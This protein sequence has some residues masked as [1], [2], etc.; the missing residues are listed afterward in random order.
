MD[1]LSKTW[2][3]HDLPAVPHLVYPAAEA[4][5]SAL[6]KIAGYAYETI[7]IFIKDRV[8][9]WGWA[10]DD[11][12]RLGKFLVENPSEIFRLAKLWE[13]YIKKFKEI[14]EKIRD[15]EK[16]SDEEL[17]SLYKKFYAVYLN[18]YSIPLLANAFDTYFQNWLQNKVKN[19]TDFLLLT[20]PVKESFTQKEVKELLSIKKG[21]DFLKNIEKHAQKYFWL[22]N[23][24]AQAKILDKDYFIK[25]H[26]SEEIIEIDKVDKKPVI[27]KYSLF[28]DLI[29]AAEEC[30]YW[31][32]ER[33]K[34]NMIA[35]HF[36][37][38]FLREF[39]KRNNMSLED[40]KNVLPYE[41]ENVDKKQIDA[42][43]Q[44]ILIVVSQDSHQIHTGKEAMDLYNKMYPSEG[45]DKTE[46]RGTPACLGKAK[47]YA[48]IIFGEKEFNKLEENDIL[49]T[50]MTRPEFVPIMSKS[51]AI[52]TDEGGITCHAAIV[53]REMDKPCIIGTNMATKILKDGDLV[54]VDA[55]NGIVKILKRK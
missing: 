17:F 42:R 15:L 24:Y 16:L 21:K 10:Y 29:K 12:E 36:L 33:K 1:I 23:N 53:A 40:M 22:Q 35:D 9:R 49:V 8:G 11:L 34:Y 6:K 47:G 26:E 37:C 3:P 45:L 51:A 54:E 14:C 46:I 5:S 2:E 18:E 50:S 30:I 28:P 13:G 20:T 44:A 55:N 27:G 39:G 25:R 19:H 7:S 32:D 38:V 41:I 31:R 43:K 4:A 52:V 48:K